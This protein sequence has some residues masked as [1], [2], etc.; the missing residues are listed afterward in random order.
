MKVAAMY[1]NRFRL[2]D[3]LG[4]YHCSGCHKNQMSTI[5]ARVLE[6]WEFKMCP[7][8]V[9]A[10]RLLDQLWMYPLFRL[11][12]LNPVLY[13]KIKSLKL[14]RLRRK[15]LKYIKDLVG[16]CRFAEKFIGMLQACPS[17]WTGDDVEIWSM[18]DFVAIKTG[19]FNKELVELIKKCGE[20]VNK[21]GVSCF[22]FNC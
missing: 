15:Q 18:S 9:F 21:C 14:A 19:T 12:D 16:V 11:C 5:P 13:T 7:V 3:Y 10:Y 17:H 8:S 2:C 1:S 20:H 6:N 22:F 4:K